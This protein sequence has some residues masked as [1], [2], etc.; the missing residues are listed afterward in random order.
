MI[1]WRWSFDGSLFSIY[2]MG[3]QGY[4]FFKLDAA[5]RE[6]TKVGPGRC[7]AHPASSREC[8]STL[9]SKFILST[10][11]W[12]LF[13][14]TGKPSSP[15]MSA[16]PC[17][18]RCACSF[19]ILSLSYAPQLLMIT[20]TYESFVEIHKASLIDLCSLVRWP[21]RVSDLNFPPPVHP[22]PFLVIS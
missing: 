19:I 1:F 4:V 3:L 22:T 18:S 13:K 20:K 8:F 17:L 15:Q 9:L 10:W 5:M 6:R 14:W 2:Q 7:Q 11:Q 12:W 16:Q 21:S